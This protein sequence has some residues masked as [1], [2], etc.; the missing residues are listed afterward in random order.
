MLFG[1]RGAPRWLAL[2]LGSAIRFVGFFFSWGV[3]NWFPMA[4]SF[5]WVPWTVWALGRASDEPRVLRRTAVAGVSCVVRRSCRPLASFATAWTIGF[6][7]ASPAL[8]LLLEHTLASERLGHSTSSAH[9]AVPLDAFL[10]VVPRVLIHRTRP[11]VLPAAEEWSRVQ[12]PHGA[13]EAAGA[14][15]FLE[16]ARRKHAELRALS[17]SPRASGLW[18]Q[19]GSERRGGAPA[20]ELARLFGISTG[21]RR[22]GPLAES[23]GSPCGAE[24]G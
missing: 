10:G 9:W 24:A 2:V 23:P 5:A 15:A 1:A 21:D 6:L 3:A 13:S 22:P 14:P 8:L 16:W 11:F 4:T 19:R 7:L 12:P 18:S 17:A 20:R